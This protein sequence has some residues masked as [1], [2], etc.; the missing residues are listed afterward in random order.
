[1]TKEDIE[2]NFN[3]VDKK[4]EE[5]SRVIKEMNTEKQKEYNELLDYL[6]QQ[7]MFKVKEE[8]KQIVEEIL[9][10]NKNEEN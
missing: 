9:L 5:I 6:F 3:K 4:I 2:F 10:E 7:V 1:M 8:I